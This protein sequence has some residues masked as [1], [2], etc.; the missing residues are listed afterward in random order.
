MRPP[1]LPGISV[2]LG[3][4]RINIIPH[5]LDHVGF[6]CWLLKLG[7]NRVNLIITYTWTICTPRT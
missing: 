7:F 4:S 6:P 5:K 2:S 1:G 3:Y